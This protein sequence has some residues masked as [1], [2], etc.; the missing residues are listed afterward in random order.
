MESQVQIVDKVFIPQL[1][2][3]TLK[4]LNLV[5]GF[6]KPVLLP[7]TLCAICGSLLFLNPIPLPRDSEGGPGRVCLSGPW[8]YHSLGKATVPAITQ[9]LS[10]GSLQQ[11]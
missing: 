1:V 8:C 5:L 9:A 3:Q 11:V 7:S 4:T 10:Q 2:L 6:H